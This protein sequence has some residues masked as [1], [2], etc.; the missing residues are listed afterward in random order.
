MT[1]E[2]DLWRT[3]VYKYLTTP[4]LKVE[5]KDPQQ[6]SYTFYGQK[7]FT[8]TVAGNYTVT[9][10][11]SGYTP[12]SYQIRV[13][14]HSCPASC[15]YSGLNYCG[16][17]GA[18]ING[19]CV[20]DTNT[21]VTLTTNCGDSFPDLIPTVV[22]LGAVAIAFIVIAVLVVCIVP[23]VICACCFGWCGFCANAMAPQPIVHVHHPSVIQQQS[24]PGPVYIQVPAAH[25]VYRDAQ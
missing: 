25:E 13:C 5:I 3:S 8:P 1:F 9:L 12:L 7:T 17:N 15:Y 22:T 23:I 24:P 21:T 14:F 18:C 6:K 20:C 2:I 4:K 19:N 16:G 11:L 10:S